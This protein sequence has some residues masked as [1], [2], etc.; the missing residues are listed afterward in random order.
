[1]DFVGLHAAAQRGIDALMP[2]NQPLTFKDAGDDGGIPV[3]TVARQ[4]DVLAINVGADEGLKFVAGQGVEK[5][6]L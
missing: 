1:M 5:L 2:L 4:F 6:G 3:P